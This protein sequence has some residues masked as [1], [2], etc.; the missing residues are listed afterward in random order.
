MISF[1]LAQASES[2]SGWFDIAQKIGSGAA[3]VMGLGIVFLWRAYAAE[4][5]YSKSRD[6]QTLTVLLNLTKIVENLESRDKEFA[7]LHK[8]STNALLSAING[9]KDLIT[10]HYIKERRR[11]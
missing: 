7:V 6:Q 1:L 8:E 3:F 10:D 11:V 9:L 4:L 2:I 5:K